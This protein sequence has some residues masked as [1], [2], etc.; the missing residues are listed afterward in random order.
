MVLEKR[1]DIAKSNYCYI[2]TSILAE[3]Y[4]HVSYEY[5][6]E[7][8]NKQCEPHVSEFLRKDIEANEKKAQDIEFSKFRI[9]E[10]IDRTLKFAGIE[11]KTLLENCKLESTQDF[12]DLKVSNMDSVNITVQKP[13]PLK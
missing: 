11:L 6:L 3:Y 12:D 1:E 4:A 2:E 13:R 9:N 10:S 7:Q 8:I 5:I